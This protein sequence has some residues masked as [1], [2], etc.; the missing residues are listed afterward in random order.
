MG[1]TI[2][3]SKEIADRICTILNK[4]EI[5]FTL[6]ERKGTIKFS[7]PVRGAADGPLKFYIFL[8]EDSSYAIHA[9]VPLQP[10]KDNSF[11]ISNLYEF[12]S[13]VNRVLTKGCMFINVNDDCEIWY[14]VY[15]DYIPGELSVQ[16]FMDTI[17]IIVKDIECYSFGILRIIYDDLP[18]KIALT[19]SENVRKQ[20]DH[21]DIIES[22]DDI[23][24][25]DRLFE[26]LLDAFDDKAGFSAIE[27][28]NDILQE[29]NDD[30]SISLFE[31]SL[32]EQ[33]EESKIYIE[34]I[35]E[36]LNLINNPNGD[37][38][39]LQVIFANRCHFNAYLDMCTAIKNDAEQDLKADW[40]I[41]RLLETMRKR[42]EELPV[43]EDA[44]GNSCCSV[45]IPTTEMDQVY[46]AL[47]QAFRLY[48]ALYRKYEER[49]AAMYELEKTIKDLNDMIDKLT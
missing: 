45:L 1:K 36:C 22:K 9:L 10:D 15:Q 24:K 6:D 34:E 2:H 43:D 14:K 48:H 5:K 47:E 11:A 39:G 26:E 27:R 28:L 20:L 18:P 42:F 38:A 49:K 41:S 4:E 16:S 19:A 46:L 8:N 32:K 21:Y 44:C 12:F 30:M 17:H 23:K 13:R 35:P 40:H 25:L 31:E 37:N 7:L 33:E 3:Y 29:E